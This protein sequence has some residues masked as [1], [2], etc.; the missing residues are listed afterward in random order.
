MPALLDELVAPR[1]R[2][3]HDE[4]SPVLILHLHHDLLSLLLLISRLLSL[5]VQVQSPRIYQYAPV[6][7]SRAN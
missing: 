5:L 3:F 7:T 4:G 6:L 2:V 1:N